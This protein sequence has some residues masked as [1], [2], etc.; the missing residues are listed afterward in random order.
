MP[1]LTWRRSFN[2]VGVSIPSLG[3]YLRM[4]R[5][6]NTHAEPAPT[7]AR[8]SWRHMVV[9]VVVVLVVLVVVG[10]LSE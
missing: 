6:L 9:V 4:S 3:S 2:S 5:K 1:W 8:I 10:V 7:S